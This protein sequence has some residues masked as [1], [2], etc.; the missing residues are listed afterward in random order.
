MSWKT[1]T[2]N[3]VTI[4]NERDY[5]MVTLHLKSEVLGETTQKTTQILKNE[6]NIIYH[7]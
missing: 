4:R 3:D 7:D 2:G 5:V 6:E 1:L